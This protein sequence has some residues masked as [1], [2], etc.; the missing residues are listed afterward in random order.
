MKVEF[1][2][3]TMAIEQQGRTLDDVYYTIK[4]LFEKYGLPCVSDDDI[5][6][7]EDTGRKN[8]FANMW[9]AIVALLKADW[10]VQWA[11]SCTWYEEDGTQEDVLS[12]AWK[13]REQKRA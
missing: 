13:F 7:F 8:D 11:S 9:L 4:K 5:L 1:A 2:F 3:D 10:F 6:A 12:Q